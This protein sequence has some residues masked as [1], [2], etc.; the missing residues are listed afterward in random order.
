MSEVQAWR[1]QTS[2]RDE[3]P[4]WVPAEAPPFGQLWPGNLIYLHTEASV[5]RVPVAE[6]QWIIR[7]NAGGFHVVDDGQQETKI[8]EL[9]AA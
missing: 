7:D 8:A 6:G 5:K 9:S 2:M 4:A 3:I 1:H